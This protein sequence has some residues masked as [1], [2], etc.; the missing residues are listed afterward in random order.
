MSN[1]VNTNATR[2]DPS[3]ARLPSSSTRS[4]FRIG[5]IEFAD[6]RGVT[7]AGLSLD[8]GGAG[9]TCTIERI[10]VDYVAVKRG[11][12]VFAVKNVTVRNVTARFDDC[13]LDPACLRSCDVAEVDVGT[14]S[15]VIRDRSTEGAHLALHGALRLD[16]IRGAH[17]LLHTFMKD[18]LWRVD[19]EAIVPVANGGVKLASIDVNHIGPDSRI[20]PGPRG[21][22]VYPPTGGSIEVL[23]FSS[24]DIDASNGT[25]DLP[26]LIEHALR[27]TSSEPIAAVDERMRSAVLR[28]RLN[29]HVQ[30]GNGA[31]GD[32]TRYA[33]L[34]GANAETNRVD[35][36]SS[37][38]GEQVTFRMGR[39]SASSVR[40]AMSGLDAEASDVS[41]G[42]EGRVLPKQVPGGRAARI[43]VDLE[44]AI[45][46]VKCRNV[47]LGRLQESP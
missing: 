24:A 12:T 47:R 11:A 39:L 32:A 18:A 46:D 1:E 17:G 33:V 25:L 20:G 23:R 38:I 43:Q 10:T 34:S 15:A 7:V 16:A 37:A 27:S 9:A 19:V 4:A 6:V 26:S 28:M 42:I 31:L 21:I 35:L 29:G 44:L 13:T 45:T 8:F 2:L 36:A 30:L 3:A 22:C 14:L 40:A 41:A 5:D